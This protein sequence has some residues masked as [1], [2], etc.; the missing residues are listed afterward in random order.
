MLKKTYLCGTPYHLL[1][2]LLMEDELNEKSIYF[3]SKSSSVLEN[4]KKILLNTDKLEEVGV[5]NIIFRKRTTLKELFFIEKL[6]DFIHLKKYKIKDVVN[7]GW[8]KDCYYFFS[9]YFSKKAERVLL[10]EDGI[11]MYRHSMSNK[12]LR[13]KKLY[14]LVT[15]PWNE[16]NV[17]EIRVQK[18]EKFPIEYRNKIKQLN[19]RKLFD[20]LPKEK[21]T[22]LVSIFFDKELS[23]KKQTKTVLILTQPL[24]EDKIISRS[25]KLELYKKLIIKNKEKTILFKPHP[26]DED[27]YEEILK[28]FNINYIRKEIPIEVINLLDLQINEVISICS[29]GTFNLFNVKKRDEI[30]P[31]L[32][33]D[34]QVYSKKEIEKKILERIINENSSNYSS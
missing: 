14:G 11:T 21:K 17:Y 20:N 4:T 29:S 19:L 2:S 32:M 22:K 25:F 30:Y 23:L 26:R 27:S 9:N 6:I 10:I 18:P 13:L 8:H 15:D 16:K 34:I 28:E 31:N 5:N 1:I 33:K 12:I 3:S 24:S 7:F